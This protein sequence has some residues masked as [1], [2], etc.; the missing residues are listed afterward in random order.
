MNELTNKRIAIVATDGFEE[1]E[2]T[3]P[4]E[5]LR[6]AGATVEILSNK[7]G[8]IQAFHH[9]DKSIA[10]PVDG[11]VSEANPN[12]YDGLILPGGALNADAMRAD[13]DVQ[14]FVRVFDQ[15]DKPVGVICHAPW[16]LVSSG[17]ARNR[18]LTSYHTIQDD[19]R[20]AGATW[21]NREVVVDGNLITSRFPGDLPAFNREFV[22][23]L[24]EGTG[25]RIDV[26]QKRVA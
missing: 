17:L 14:A 19:L 24:V 3:K 10:V 6:D 22:R 18:T 9:H 4:V 21:I 5:A 11:L 23:M 7:T 13:R 26:I 2:L 16:I 15:A 20:N 1:T 12:R 25:R 8:Q